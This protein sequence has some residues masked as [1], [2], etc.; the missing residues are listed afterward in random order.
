MHLV[1]AVVVRVR[2]VHLSMK[3]SGRKSANKIFWEIPELYMRQSSAESGGITTYSALLL[4][5]NGPY[6][7]FHFCTFSFGLK[8]DS[9]F[10]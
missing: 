7:N 4:C 3:L 9:L 1:N 6:S 8:M 10:R 5:L 2:P